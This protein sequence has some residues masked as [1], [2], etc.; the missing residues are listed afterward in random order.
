MDEVPVAN[1]N[2]V[3][4]IIKKPEVAKP[5]TKKAR[6][7]ETLK[8]FFY[9]LPLAMVVLIQLYYLGRSFGSYT[10]F[11]YASFT[12]Y[13][14][15]TSIALL[16]LFTQMLIRSIIYSTLAGAIFIAGILSMWFGDFITPISQ[17]YKELITIVASAWTN[18]DIPFSLM[19]TGIMTLMLVS[20][21]FIQFFLSLIVK[22]FFESIFGKEWGDGKI[23]GYLGAISLLL[24]V[25]LGFYFY[26]SSAS[27]V[28][29]R[30]V[31]SR[32]ERYAPVE[33]FLTLT[34]GKI[35]V[36]DSFVWI[37]NAD[38]TVAFNKNNGKEIGRIYESP[39]AVHKGF[40]NTQNPILF[41]ANKILSY[42]SDL[43]QNFWDKSY[44]E[45]FPGMDLADVNAMAFN[46]KPLTSYL[47]QNTELLLVIYEYGYAGLY[48]TSD[49]TNLWLNRIDSQRQVN[50]TFQ[51]KHFERD[52]FIIT[53]NLLVFSGSN[54]TV[55]ALEIKSG[56]LLWAYQH[57]SPKHTGQ[58]QKGY[59]SRMGDKAVVA[60]KSGEI[61]T[62]ALEDGRRIYRIDNSNYSADT[63]LHCKDRFAG[64][65]T[66]IGIY[67]YIDLDGGEAA[68]TVNLLPRKSSLLPVV[69]D[70]KHGIVAHRDEVLK[71]DN[72]SKTVTRIL[73]AE[74]QNFITNPVFDQKLMYIG[75][76]DGWLYC[77]HTGSKHEKW[78]VHINGELVNDSL[79][80]SD[81]K[82]LVKTKS[83][84]ISVFNA[85]LYPDS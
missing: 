1:P 39:I 14:F 19:T 33:K 79:H 34:P 7:I 20:F 56:N 76:Q 49:G 18:K 37:S 10:T 55:R 84:S 50:R 78:R 54:G 4:I 82:L 15:L 25:H 52:Y 73:H 32:Y 35:Q 6:L 71:I 61:V 74:K 42:S 11:P 43:K 22:S 47:L 60:F 12:T 64:L 51:E 45:K 38:K 9:M 65:L 46:N 21:T 36:S 81:N 44:P 53:E 68:Y 27:N 24:G 16:F 41:T 72:E 66:N 17:N 75:T 23:L 67:F 30:L 48:K 8:N 26:A 5:K 63:P 2:P 69:S 83:G 13:V 58:G 28:E 59:I 70:L 57:D 31:W 85:E 29:D 77:V 40:R 3:N 80:L 62:L